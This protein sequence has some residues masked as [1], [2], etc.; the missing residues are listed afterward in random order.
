MLDLYCPHCGRL[1]P[2]E[3]NRRAHIKRRHSKRHKSAAWSGVAPSVPWAM[4]PIQCRECTATFGSE[5]WRQR[6][7][8]AFHAPTMSLAIADRAARI[9]AA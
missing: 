3:S 5:F 1:F 9:V 7:A 6:H 8:A 4:K 2:R